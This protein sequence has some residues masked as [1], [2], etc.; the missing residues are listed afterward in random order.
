ME[1]GNRLLKGTPFLTGDEAAVLRFTRPIKRRRRLVQS[2]FLVGIASLG[3]AITILQVA[4]VLVVG[5]GFGGLSSAFIV[6]HLAVGKR[7]WMVPVEAFEDGFAGSEVTLFFCRRR[8]VPWNRVESIE[9][10]GA[11]GETP[12][13]VIHFGGSRTLASAP[14]EVDGAGL[15]TL[16]KRWEQ[17]KAE[18]EAARAIFDSVGKESPKDG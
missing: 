4:D 3:G 7:K 16:Q 13:L 5:V 11:L 2:A 10:E 17:V 8:F 6:G 12:R 14:H 18:A 15:A 9:L 1:R